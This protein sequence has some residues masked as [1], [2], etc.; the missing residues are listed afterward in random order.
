MPLRAQFSRAVAKCAGE[1]GAPLSRVRCARS[2]HEIAEFSANSRVLRTFAFWASQNWVGAMPRRGSRG[3]RAT[4]R[5]TPSPRPPLGLHRAH[6]SVHIRNVHQHSNMSPVLR[7]DERL[8][9]GDTQ[10]PEELLALRRGE[11]MISV[12]HIVVTDYGRHGSPWAYWAD[13]GARPRCAGPY[14]YVPH[15]YPGSR[16]PGRQ[17][18]ASTLRAR[19][20]NRLPHQMPSGSRPRGQERTKLALDDSVQSVQRRHR[21][22]TRTAYV[23]RRKP[24]TARSSIAAESARS[25][26]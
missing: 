2:T 18:R 13:G 23:L 6:E 25:W 17:R 26:R 12:L 5:R 15:A 22:W 20:T 10:G 11:P 3:F 19:Y 9:V 1:H 21:E 4:R 14:T 8:N 24:R 16:R 7:I